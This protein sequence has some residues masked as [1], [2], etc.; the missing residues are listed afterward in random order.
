[1]TRF[2]LATAAALALL[3]G[4]ALAADLPPAPMPAYKAPAV[5]APSFSWSGC[6]LYGGA[7]YGLW[8]QD[9]TSELTVGLVPVS[10]KTTT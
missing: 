4:T 5:V 1:M 7:G 8:N 6:Y 3:S 10:V 2:F 9:S